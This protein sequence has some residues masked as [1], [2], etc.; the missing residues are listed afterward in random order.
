MP[1]NIKL[2]ME[3]DGTDFH[4]WQVQPNLRTVQGEIQLGLEA[5]LK[6]QVNLIGSGRTD[7]G[8]HALGQVAN[9]KTDSPLHVESIFRAL[10]GL[11]PDDIVIT[12]AEEVSSE[13]NS[14]YSAKSRVYKYRVHPGRTAI[15][16]RYVWEV[17]YTLDPK[18]MYEVTESIPG[19][20]DFSSLCVAESSKNSNLCRVFSAFWESS[21]NELVFEIEADRFL[22]TMVR[23]LVGTLIEVGRGY[24]SAADFLEIM[25]AKDRT[26]AGPTAPACGLYLVE[27]KY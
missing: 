23:S 19:E 17:Q 1:R 7:V 15:L 11:L 10:N 6:H 5:I 25:K 13:F 20:H 27:V 16:R 2:Q 4:G 24:F 8:V 21:G 9:F 18:A 12:Q 14:R 22:H 26:R 3:Y